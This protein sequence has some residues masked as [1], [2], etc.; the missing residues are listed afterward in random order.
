MITEDG[1]FGAGLNIGYQGIEFAEVDGL[2]GDD[3]FYVLSTNADVETTIIGGLGADVFNVA[4]DVT[5]PIVSYSVEGRSSF[6]NHSVFSD[7]EAITA[8]S[9]TVFL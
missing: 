7:D 6:I 9:L 8:F 1:I 3:T 4:S 2:E 5:K